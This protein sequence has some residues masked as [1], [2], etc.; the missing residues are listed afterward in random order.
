MH[1]TRQKR[2]GSQMENP[3]SQLITKTDVAR[4][5]NT[6]L[7]EPYKCKSRRSENCSCV[8]QMM[9]T[10]VG[11]NEQQFNDLYFKTNAALLIMFRVHGKGNSRPPGEKDL[12]QKRLQAIYILIAYNHCPV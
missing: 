10:S 3:K 5:Q 8:L 4:V 6:W 2:S 12:V 11:R 1:L 7:G 9:W